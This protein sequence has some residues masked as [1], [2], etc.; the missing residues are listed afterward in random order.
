MHIAFR[1]AVAVVAAVGSV[2]LAVACSSDGSGSSS[3][4]SGGTKISFQLN[5][6]PGGSNAGFAAAVEEGYYKAAGLDVTIVPGTGSSLTA[7]MVASGQAS[8]GYADSTATA[9]LIA[10]QAPL[11]VLATVY[12]SNPNAVLALPGSGITSVRDLKGKKVGT[13]VPS[14]QAT[15]LPLFLAANGLSA[16]DV[17]LVNLAPTSL[18][19]SLLQH[20]VDAILGSTDAYQV[21]LEQQNAGKLFVAPFATNGVPTVSTS[22][23]AD[24]DWAAS[25]A[26]E[27]KA[28][29]KASLQGWH[30]A[31]T[32]PDKATADVTKLWG[33]KADKASGAELKAIIGSN[34]MCAGGAKFLGKAEPAQW[35]KT[36]DLL[37]QVG[38]LP[39]G[40]DPTKYYS[41]DYLPA[42]L[43]P[44]PVK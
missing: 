24:K 39:K 18:V 32:N 36:Q 12:Q 14:S 42:D 17:N 29:V 38:L 43:Q 23:F 2:S 31:A 3:D 16:K 11:S 9:Q 10:K 41:Y 27:V 30:F 13:P 19:Q 37:S 26:T 35:V 15:M 22:I 6:P 20:R 33:A 1:R 34:L 25:H 21:Q 40:V 28:F 8:I 4:G 44:C 7:Q 5:F